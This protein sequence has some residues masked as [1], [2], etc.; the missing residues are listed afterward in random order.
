MKDRDLRTVIHLIHQERTYETKLVDKSLYKLLY[1]VQKSANEKDVDITIPYFW[2]QFGTV[3]PL[4]TV[5]PELDLPDQSES[6][7]E[8]LRPLIKEALG[9]YY[10]DKL[11]GITDIMYQDA[12]YDVQREF[13]ELDKKVRTLHDDYN[14]FY[15]VEP[16]RD[17]IIDT[18]YAVHDT[19]PTVKFREQEQDL[20]KWYTMFTREVDKTNYDPDKLMKINLTFWRTFALRVAENHRHEMTK[21]EV[22]KE[23]GITS[24]EAARESTRKKLR[25]IESRTLAEKFEG[26]DRPQPASIE[27]KA[28]DAMMEPILVQE[29]GLSFSD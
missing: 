28:A 27:S 9:L 26:E 19:F 10:D 22:K 8:E 6:L 21:Q 12:P 29:L 1:T 3:S 25:G 2:Y 7:K 24:F 15:E 20:S 23:I 5:G 17:S 16:S 18:V 4:P 14:D 11:E 13:R